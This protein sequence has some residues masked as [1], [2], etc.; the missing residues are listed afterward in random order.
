MVARLGGDEFAILPDQRSVD[1]GEIGEL[2]ERLLDCVRAP[3]R[4]E[5]ISLELGASLGASRFPRDGADESTLMRR[6][7]VAMY[8]AK[9]THRGSCL[10]NADQ[11][12][13][14][15]QR[16]SVT[17]DI[18]RAI[19]AGE[20]V[21]HF[22]PIVELPGQR[23]R[24]AEGLVRWQHPT[25][26]LLPPA[27][28]I[29]TIEQTGLIGPLTEH[30]LD[31][32]VEQCARWQA[33]GDRLSVA[34]N[35][36]VR[37]LLDQS[38]PRTIE[39]TLSRWG[40]RPEALQLEITE[41]MLMSDPTR[42]LDTI[43]RISDLGVRFA[44]DDF[45]TGYSSLVY[46]RRLPIREL[47]IDRSFVTPMLSDP[48]DLIIVRSTINLA[49]DLGLRIVAEGVEDEATAE[50]LEGLGCDLAQGFHFGRPVAS[51]PFS[52]RLRASLL[53]LVEGRRV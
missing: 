25:H 30:V 13:N 41:S 5:G 10:Y 20:I 48:S 22:Q 31:R 7:D 49:H 23:I 36:S 45:G 24:S 3:I 47:K 33:D 46:L 28:F 18:R 34:V 53:G 11:D 40:L 1:R 35:L 17:S 50:C 6:A 51:G 43:S 52:D 44:V 4:V 9:A 42:A 26:G 15:L 14:A 29:S 16:L 39:R 12:R 2:T 37:D 19:G 8:T 38:L 32:A 27:A 21:V